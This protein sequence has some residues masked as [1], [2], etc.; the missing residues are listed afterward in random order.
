MS[1]TVK[2]LIIL[3]LAQACVSINIVLSKNLIGH[4]D[5]LIILTIRFTLASIFILFLLLN[6]KS[7]NKFNLNLSAFDWLILIISGLGAGILFNYAKRF[8]LY[9]CY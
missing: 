9:R 7:P 2:P 5:P 4:I 8:T 3:F 1:K 6:S